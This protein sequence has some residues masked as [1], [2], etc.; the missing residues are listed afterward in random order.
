MNED[1]LKEVIADC[2][3]EAFDLGWNTALLSV[4]AAID[5]MK[6]LGT[7]AESFAAF[8]REFKRDDTR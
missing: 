4:A 3:K 6:A 5:N 1:E 2:A 7:T 8:V